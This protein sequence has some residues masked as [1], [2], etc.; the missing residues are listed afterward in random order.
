M[1]K[2]TPNGRR[3]ARQTLLLVLRGVERLQR[4]LILKRRGR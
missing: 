2:G 3:W 4:S 1:F